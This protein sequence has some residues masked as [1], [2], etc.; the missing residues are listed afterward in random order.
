MPCRFLED[1]GIEY[2][3]EYLNLPADVV[4]ATL[5]KSARPAGEGRRPPM[6]DRPPRGPPREGG[7]RDGY[8][9]GPREGGGFGRGGGG[10]KVGQQAWK[11]PG[12][13]F[14]WGQQGEGGSSVNVLACLLHHAVKESSLLYRVLL[15]KID[16]WGRF[17]QG[18]PTQVV[19]LQYRNPGGS[20]DGHT[21]MM[22]ATAVSGRGC[23][24][25]CYLSICCWAVHHV[26]PLLVYVLKRLRYVA[27]AAVGIDC[28]V[29]LAV[30]QG[31]CGMAVLTCFHACSCLFDLLRAGH[32][33]RLLRATVW[34]WWWR[35]RPRQSSS[36]SCSTMQRGGG[37]KGVQQLPE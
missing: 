36:M 11:G 20:S 29:G 10:D 5:K 4:P 7:Y 16:T 25:T 14:S 34:Q 21:A 9:S 33:P 19:V 35:L 37:M 3:R 12:S 24:W 6:G 18:Y 1:K 27:A 23:R 17:L 26:E 13:S 15:D 2:L 8:R 31:L 28:W 32:R 22:C 30:L